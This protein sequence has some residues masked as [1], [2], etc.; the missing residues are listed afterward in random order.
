MKK[1]KYNIEVNDNGLLIFNTLSK[2]L[3]CLNSEAEKMYAQGIFVNSEFTEKL[4]KK[5]II[6]DDDF[7]EFRYARFN[8]YKK[9]F[10]DDLLEIT[11]IP[12]QNCNFRCQYCFEPEEYSVMSY[13]IAERILKYL[14]KNLM[15]YKELVID[16]FGGEPLLGR[17]IV[18]YIM[19]EIK[20]LCREYGVV[21]YSTMFTNGYELKRNLFEKLVDSGV[22]YFTICI[23]GN[24]ETHNIQ[25]P[26]KTDKDSYTR[27]VNNL[28]DISQN[29]KSNSDKFKILI[30]M[31]V[32]E[33]NVHTA[34]EFVKFYQ[35]NFGEDHRFNIVWQWVHNWGGERINET[36]LNEKLLGEDK[37]A[38][39][40]E[41]SLS[42]G[43]ISDEELSANS[44]REF[45]GAGKK[46]G[47]LIDCDGKLYKCYMAKTNPKTQDN[48]VLGFINS[49]G[50]LV[51]DDK[52]N[53]QWVMP[54]EPGDK[55]R[56]CV[57]FPLCTG[58]SCPLSDNVIHK[59]A[60]CFTYKKQMIQKIKNKKRCGKVEY[61]TINAGENM[62]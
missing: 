30:R 41:Y 21:L 19:N 4:L 32:S 14:K 16:W 57:Y 52:I 18:L 45:C 47:F 49:S 22:R 10:S 11:I 9:I 42:L 31:N 50:K 60:R 38:E 24:R 33:Q 48:A 5:N 35:E 25:R 43:L 54:V 34:K 20:Q 51:I 6:V 13:D 53:S 37:C 23:D 29:I 62:Q 46:N 58:S 55:C 61:I 36:G 12:T 3:I 28:L 39:L 7:D 2:E 40:Y 8:H 26:H 59:K 56:D 1:S 27:I 15:R 17:D 44:G